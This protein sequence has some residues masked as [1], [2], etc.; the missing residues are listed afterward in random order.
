MSRRIQI[1]ASLKLRRKYQRLLTSTWTARTLDEV[2]SILVE[3]LAGSKLPF[4]AKNKRLGGNHQG[5]DGFDSN[6]L[7]VS[8]IHDFMKT[9]NVSALPHFPSRLPTRDRGPSA[10]WRAKANRTWTLLVIQALGRLRGEI[11]FLRD[12]QSLLF[13]VTRHFL[14]PTLK[15]LNMEPEHDLLVHAMYMHTM[16]AWQDFPSHQYYLKSVLL[17]YLGETEQA[18]KSLLASF[19]TTSPQDH[20]YLSKAQAYWSYLLD[21]GQYDKA[22]S[23]LLELYRTAPAVC[24]SEIQEMINDLFQ[25]WSKKK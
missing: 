19:E 18:G 15:S 22:K 25:F 4:L 10:R 8:T 17:D 2:L 9:L 23:F 6:S 24:L 16:L 20:D 1:S 21:C 3:E 5:F 14:L 13:L 11:G 12:C 7:V